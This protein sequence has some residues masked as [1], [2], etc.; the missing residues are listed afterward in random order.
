MLKIATPISHL[1]DEKEEYAVGIQE[2]SDCFR[3]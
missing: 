3:K 2:L 1:F